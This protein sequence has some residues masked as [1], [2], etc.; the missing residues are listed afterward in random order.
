MPQ[1]LQELEAR[2]QVEDVEGKAAQDDENNDQKKGAPS[3][4][5]MEDLLKFGHEYLYHKEQ[6]P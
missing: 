4:R 6:H 2:S 3:Y 5:F 1:C